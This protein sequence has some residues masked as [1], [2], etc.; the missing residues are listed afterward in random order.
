MCILYL[1]LNGRRQLQDLNIYDDGGCP[2][3]GCPYGYNNNDECVDLHYSIPCTYIETW[4][5]R[6]LSHSH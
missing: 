1:I 4:A 6:S 2:C 5:L 3:L